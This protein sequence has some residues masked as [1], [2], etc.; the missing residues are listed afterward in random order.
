MKKSLI[1]ILAV[2]MMA[3][4]LSGCDGATYTFTS[5]GGKTTI[6]V[7]QASDGAD[8]E[9]SVLSVGKNR[10]AAIESSLDKGRL[11]IDFVDATVFPGGE[12]LPDEVVLNDTVASITVGPGSIES[13][14][15][16]Q[17]DYVMQV[18][19]IGETNGKIT[20]NIEKN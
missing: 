10:S 12:D 20:V 17:G 19:A 16:E 8:A 13:I 1:A 15:L 5:F 3:M 4:V 14:P 7:N 18:K 9:S 2:L 11:Q 6:E